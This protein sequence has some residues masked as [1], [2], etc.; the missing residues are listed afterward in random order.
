MGGDAVAGIGMGKMTIDLRRSA[1]DRL[2]DV[3]GKGN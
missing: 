3:S 1:S 2:V